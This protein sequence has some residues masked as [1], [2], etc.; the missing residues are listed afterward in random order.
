MDGLAD[1]LAEVLY[2][3]CGKK[4][5][6]Q[7]IKSS[8]KADF[9]VPIGF[10]LAGE[11]K[12]NPHEIAADIALKIPVVGLIKSVSSDG[13]YV[14]F[15]LDRSLTCEKTI[16]SPFFTP[17]NCE[18]IILEH[19]S[20]NPTGPIHVGRIR[21]TLIGDSLKRILEYVGYDVETH[22]FVNDMGRQVALITLGFEQGLIPDLKLMERFSRY[23]ERGDFKM[24]FTYVVANALTESDMSF[25]KKVGE[26]LRDAESNEGDALNRI[27]EIAKKGLEGQMETFKRLNI[28]FDVFDWESEGILDGGVSEVLEK[29]RES[30]LYVNNEVGEGVDLTSYGIE[31][32][33][34]MSVLARSNGTSV[35][36]TRDIAYHLK[37]IS[38]ADR[39]INVLGEDH[40]LQF[41]ELTAILKHVFKVEKNLDVVHFSFVNFD[42]VQFSTRKGDIATVD[43]L[44]DD[45]VAKALEEVKKRG[46]GDIETASMV[47]IGAVKFHIIKTTPNKQINFRFED[48]LNFDG[49][50]A[51]YIQYSHARC[52]RIL[53]KEDLLEDAE[54]SYVDLH[55]SEWGLI[56]AQTNFS[57]SVK[58]AASSLRPDIIASYLITLSSAY[59]RFYMDCPVLDS[60]DS[61]KNR[62][63]KIVKRT[64][65]IIFEGL[66]LLGIDAP[67]KM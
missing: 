54:I 53:E 50:T 57:A 23:R 30:D 19:T 16:N 31:K 2:D 63:L 4:I 20:V 55:D 21:N 36:L 64:K 40:K 66:G 44:L 45:A 13:G 48:A 17:H 38:L 67:A 62:R 15:G 28:S 25:S 49:E 52:C 14:N 65:D 27:T 18:K 11:L 59:G 32:S 56:L 39:L 47:G 10:I 43:E 51:P 37:K 35:Y 58:S 9:G 26:L 12:S 60:T 3:V 24:L 42:G 22:Y 46:L 34:G 1:F 41:R 6:P 61:V 33:A 29:I 5:Q 7:D 8:P